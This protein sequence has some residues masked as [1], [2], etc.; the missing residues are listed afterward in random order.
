[1]LVKVYGASVRGLS[2]IP[3]TIEVNASRGIKFK[4]IVLQE[5]ALIESHE[6]IEAA[7]EKS[8]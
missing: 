6:R 2:A 5:N 8:G 7:V 3:V 1:M 4:L